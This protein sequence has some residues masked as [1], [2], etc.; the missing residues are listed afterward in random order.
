M[1]NYKLLLI[2]TLVIMLSLAAVI[3]FYPPSED[4]GEGNP[5]WNG[6]KTF[7][8]EFEALSINSLDDL[9][10][11]PGETVLVSIPYLDFTEQEMERLKDYVSQG[12]TLI[13]LDDYGYGN[14]ILNYL[15][16]DFRFIKYQLLDPLSNGQNEFYPRITTFASASVTENLESILLN[17]ATGLSSSSLEGVIAWSSRFSFL[18]INNNS[19]WDEEEPK[20]PIPVA[21]AQP[22]DDG[23]VV[24]I[25]DPSILINSMEGRD[26][27][28]K[29][30]ENIT[31]IQSSDPEILVDQSHLSK[32]SLYNVKEGLDTARSWFSSTPALSGLIVAA[33]IVTL[34]PLWI[35]KRVIV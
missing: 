18:D 32:T 22:V 15:E 31:K 16:I 17:H 9:P 4:F 23:Y 34:R 2:L 28:H 27:N 24:L 10:I 1:R 12:G 11:N 3:W 14:E 26:S 33:L 5:F 29:F 6:L 20:G 19:I 25:S 35:K 30:I 8:N 21:A 13:L 7:Y